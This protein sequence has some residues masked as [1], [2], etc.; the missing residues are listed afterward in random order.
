M[1]SLTGS[2]INLRAL[3]RLLHQKLPLNTG[4]VEESPGEA[5]QPRKQ[6]SSNFAITSTVQE[7]RLPKH[8]PFPLLFLRKSSHCL[9]SS[10]WKMLSGPRPMQFQGLQPWFETNSGSG[11][12]DL[13]SRACGHRPSPGSALSPEVTQVLVPASIHTHGRW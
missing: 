8:N 3:C 12:P 4:Y 13:P 10:S 5:W 9:P 2:V 1:P 7:T 6:G 11:L